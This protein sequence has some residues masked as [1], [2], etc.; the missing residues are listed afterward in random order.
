MEWLSGSLDSHLGRTNVEIQA[1]KQESFD[2]LRRWL[3]IQEPIS[4]IDVMLNDLESMNLAGVKRVPQSWEARLIRLRH[5]LPST[6]VGDLRARVA[7]VR[8]MDA[9]FEIQ[10]QLFDLKMGPDRRAL[11]ERE[12]SDDDGWPA[13]DDLLP[14]TV[15]S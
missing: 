8:L 10:D 1:G 3:R 7:P 15:A 5:L 11:L 4:F 2:R 12:E 9:L 14:G 6:C 13:I